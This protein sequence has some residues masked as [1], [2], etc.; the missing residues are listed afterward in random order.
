[1]GETRAQLCVLKL[2]SIAVRTQDLP[3]LG[4]VMGGF[5]FRC[6]GTRRSCTRWAGGTG[7]GQLGREE[8]IGDLTAACGVLESS[9]KTDVSKCFSVMPDDTTKGSG[10]KLQLGKSS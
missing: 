1:L 8:A 2:G 4:Q 9:D 6:L 10:H 3:L 7:L 5:T